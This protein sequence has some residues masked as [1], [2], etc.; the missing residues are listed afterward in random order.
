MDYT[1]TLTDA[2]NK[3]MEYIAADVQEWIDNAVK[4]RCRIAINEICQIYTNHK[5]ENDQP[6]TATNKPD[7]VIAAF[8]EG[9]LL[10][11]E[12]RNNQPPIGF[13]TT[14]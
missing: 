8:N 2:E 11:A 3:A 6:I 9:I 7:M 12:D 4:N 13:G 1:V 14:P 10:T 5:L